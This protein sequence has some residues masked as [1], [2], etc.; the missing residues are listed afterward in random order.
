YIYK[1]SAIWALRYTQG[2]DVFRA[3]PLADGVG[4]KVRRSLINLPST[5]RGRKYQFF[6]DEDMFYIMDGVKPEPIFEEKIRS[7]I[8][9]LRDDGNY[10]K[11]FSV[12]NPIDDELWFC[13]PEA[14]SSTCTLAAMWN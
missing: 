3:D 13:F 9:K 14:G 7:E 1:E 4:L 12:V 6:A 5:T 10:G 2:A 8:G 11:S